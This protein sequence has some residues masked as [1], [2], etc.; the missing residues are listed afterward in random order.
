MS[1]ARA[2]RSLISLCEICVSAQPEC[3]GSN[4]YL[5]PLHLTNSGPTIV[6]HDVAGPNPRLTTCLSFFRL[7]LLYFFLSTTMYAADDHESDSSPRYP[8]R[9]RRRNKTTQ[10][11]FIL[12]P[13]AHYFNPSLPRGFLALDNATM[14]GSSVDAPAVVLS[15]PSSSRPSQTSP[16]SL[17]DSS[18]P[19]PS[20]LSNLSL[21]SPSMSSKCVL[22]SPARHSTVRTP[23]TM[24]SSPGSYSI[25]SLSRPGT[26]ESPSPSLGSRFDSSL[27]QLTKKFVHI[28]R[29]APGSRIDLNRA[30]K[31]LGVQKRRIYDITN[32]LEGIGLIQKEGKNHVAWNDDPSVDLSRAPDPVEGSEASQ[33]RIE[34][35][36]KEVADF[37]EE[38]AALDRFLD[39]LSRQSAFLSAPGTT[40]SSSPFR[41]FLPSGVED[42]Q[43]L[44]FARY[45]DVTS[46]S[47]PSDTIIG[48]KAPV[49]TNLE[50]PDPDQDAPPWMRKYQMYLNS[51]EPAPGET[52]PEGAPPI[53]VYLIRPE[54]GPHSPSRGA[55]I[56]PSRG[57]DTDH[58][59][60]E[61]PGAGASAA[62]A[63]ETEHSSQ[64]LAGPNHAEFPPMGDHNVTPR[65][66][67]S[68]RL[69]RPEDAFGPL[70]PPW[71]RTGH[72]MN[73]YD[74]RGMPTAPP[75]P[76]ASGSFAERPASPIGMPHDPWQSPSR[77]FLPPSFL[78]SPS[79]SMPFSPLPPAHPHHPTGDVH[80]PMP[81]LP[82]SD[83]RGYGGEPDPAD[84]PNVPP[85]RP[86]R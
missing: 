17:C 6:R 55:S 45:A 43:S 46:S 72:F 19:Q 44:M 84:N 31:E 83:R 9:R 40:A 7:L 13:S 35:L 42:P 82:P 56:D 30:A 57:I 71:S 15:S 50:V 37:N 21:S 14:L 79:A 67:P 12:T 34:S 2:V 51:T 3:D 29:S 53:N 61:R 49:G 28:L 4:G 68:G 32:V 76:L 24:S 33:G 10:K 39:F 52:R 48:I 47:N 85:R 18:P 1:T 80:F 66:N 54:I 60:E 77:G 23:S 64:Q 62:G 73:V 78:S 75:T 25:G 26:V 69:G 74:P 63:S 70:S 65:R 16:T 81:P 59:S 8:L 58:R 11:C 22:N 36:R 27:G 86:R 20:S 41:R 38:N 5:F